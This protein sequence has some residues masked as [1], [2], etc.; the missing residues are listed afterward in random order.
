MN[1]VLTPNILSRTSRARALL[2][3]I[4]VGAP[5][6][7]IRIRYKK[8]TNLDPLSVIFSKLLAIYEKKSGDILRAYE[9][10]YPGFA[11]QYTINDKNAPFPSK[12]LKDLEPDIFISGYGKKCQPARAHPSII[13][14]EEADDMKE[15]VLWFPRNEDARPYV[16]RDTEYSH[17]GV[18]R[19]KLENKN[20]YPFLP[21]CFL[22]NQEKRK[23]Y[24][25]FIGEDKK[26]D[27]QEGSIYIIQTNKQLEKNIVG[28]LPFFIHSSLSAALGDMD[29]FRIGVSKTRFSFL[30]CVYKCANQTTESR[31]RD[32]FENILL[33]ISKN[34]QLCM[35]QAYDMSEE[36][37]VAELT[38]STS[39]I[40]PS[41][42]YRLLERYFNCRILLFTRTAEFPEGD[43]LVPRFKHF[44]TKIEYPGDIPIILIYE[45]TGTALNESPRC[46]IIANIQSNE[47]RDMY[48]SEDELKLFLKMYDNKIVS[49][50]DNT[51]FQALP[52]TLP[53]KSQYIDVN[54]KCIAVKYRGIIIHIDPT[55]PF[56]VPT[57]NNKYL[58]KEY[59]ITDIIK[60]FGKE[61]IKSKEEEHVEI[62]L[63]G[64]KGRIITRRPPARHSQLDAISDAEKTSRCA[65]ELVLYLISALAQ[66][67]GD[68]ID[69]DLVE[70]FIRK[71]ISVNSA[72]A[73]AIEVPR[74]DKIRDLAK[75]FMI[76]RKFIVSS[77]HE[78]QLLKEFIQ[79]NIYQRTREISEYYK[80]DKIYNY[81]A[82]PGDFDPGEFVIVASWE[83]YIHRMNFKSISREEIY[84][85][86]NRD[87]SLYYFQ[88]NL[89][90]VHIYLAQTA[91]SLD[92]AIDVCKDWAKDNLNSFYLAGDAEFDLEEELFGKDLQFTLFSF[93]GSE[94]VDKYIVAG[95]EN[96]YDIKIIGYK[97]EGNEY[98]ISLLR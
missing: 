86:P 88:N 98:F 93:D 77:E 7:Q 35:E 84:D 19:N 96:N 94:K 74:S 37:I 21:C 95:E 56:D 22:V 17:A 58:Q 78:R 23:V 6:L 82:G 90:D 59:K 61:S 41:L 79:N 32:F 26:E 80:R 30:E 18:I 20:K 34:I 69:N 54:G 76:K 29:F 38:N 33:E 25:E 39:Y 45:N 57:F 55:H 92:R 15:D 8:K 1:I 66:K 11:F 44:L 4:P 71:Y 81:Y 89:I 5:F 48:F 28:R 24:R 9:K 72:A 43:I 73:A 75:I 91:E 67:S 63:M 70:F 13:S 16:C 49:Y 64:I 27:E 10:I 36:M 53:F 31:P 83:N 65:G 3:Q 46:E 42:Y 50:N 97:Y 51:K 14:N 12:H 62:E 68:E 87:L 85:Y 2:P 52:L 40:D 60:I 47:I